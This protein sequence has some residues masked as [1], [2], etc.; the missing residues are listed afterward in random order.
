L[1]YIFEERNI[2]YCISSTYKKTGTGKWCSIKIVNPGQITPVWGGHFYRFL[3]MRFNMQVLKE[4]YSEN[5]Q[6][7]LLASLRGNFIPSHENAFVKLTG[8][9]PADSVL[10]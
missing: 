8:I 2:I 3:Q 5:W 4:R 1:R 7:G 6:I 10:T 9:L